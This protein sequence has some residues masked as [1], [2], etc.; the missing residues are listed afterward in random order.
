MEFV[1]NPGNVNNVPAGVYLARE[2]EPMEYVFMV[3]KGQILL[4]NGG[5]SVTCGSGC[6]IGLNDYLAGRYTSSIFVKEDSSVFAFPS[7]AEKTPEQLFNTKKEYAGIAVWTLART[8][9]AYDR[10]EHE[11]EV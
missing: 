3:L 11:M 6:F 10:H 8:I 5:C 1:I 9:Y 4:E 2:N 7:K